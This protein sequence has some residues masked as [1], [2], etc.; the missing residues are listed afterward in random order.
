MSAN[1]WGYAV[2]RVHGICSRPRD[3][4]GPRPWTPEES[5]RAD[6]ALFSRAS[7]PPWAWH[8]RRCTRS[9]VRR[10][11]LG[12]AGSRGKTAGRDWGRGAARGSPSQS[13]GATDLAFLSRLV[14]PGGPGRGLPGW[15]GGQMSHA[16]GIFPCP[17][18]PSAKEGSPAPASRMLLGGR[19]TQR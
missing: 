6:A 2:P 17:G 19:G 14:F 16:Q 7:C 8:G 3:G 18:G 10:P 11:D 12:N 4:R 1:P 13:H 9:P 15:G 5:P